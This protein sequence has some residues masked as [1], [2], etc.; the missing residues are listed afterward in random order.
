MAS[1]SEPQP[2][3]N[4]SL[5]KPLPWIS[6]G[7]TPT[8]VRPL[9]TLGKELALSELWLKDDGQS[10][11]LYGGNKV[12]KLEFLLA[13]TLQRQRKRVMTFGALGSHHCLATAAFGQK[14]GLGVDLYLYPQPLSHHVLNNL[15]LDSSFAANMIRVPHVGLLPIHA[16]LGALR[17]GNH[18]G[19]KEIIPPGG[20]DPLGTMGYVEAALELHEQVRAGLCPEPDFIYV[21][22][23]TCGTAAGLALG[24]LLTGLKTKV[25][26]VQVV[27][28]I[29]T[30][31]LILNSLARLTIRQLRRH[32]LKMKD[33]APPNLI[34][35][36]GHL[37]K[38][39]G[40]PTDEAM[41]ALD[42][43]F[44][45]ESIKLEPTYT[46]KTLAGMKDFIR[47]QG[48]EKRCHMFW[49]TVSTVDFSETLKT[50]S[51]SD[52]PAGFHQ[53]FRAL[54]RF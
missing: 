36:K 1:N 28:S 7:T 14:I 15:L 13:R 5:K 25:I 43:L 45:A 33:Q 37:G 19:P 51:P 23:G 17:R 9:R 3:L 42:Q 20:S 53:D 8:P 11:D 40:H 24:L 34:L 31:T 48:L 39:Y 47:S 21:A 50:L 54:E 26:A 2:R 32:G 46:S 44:K 41:A 38:G 16:S 4:R 10:S 52:L 35:K 12:R 6:L 29:I 22:A 18:K 49:N 30:N 27:E